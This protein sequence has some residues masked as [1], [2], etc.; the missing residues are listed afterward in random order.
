MNKVAKIIS[1]T[2]SPE[3]NSTLE[4]GESSDN[5]SHL[6]TQPQSLTALK[7]LRLFDIYKFSNM[8]THIG[9]VTCVGIFNRPTFV[10]Y[11]FVPIAYWLL[12]GLENC[13]RF[14]EWLRYFSR[15]LLSLIRFAAP[16]AALFVLFDTVYFYH[17]T[18][19]K[20]FNDVILK[21]RKLIF[22][23]YNFFAY[24]SKAENLREH[25][26]HPFHQH[27]LNCFLLFGFNH[28]ILMLICVQFF[29]QVLGSLSLGETN[30][31]M[32]AAIELYKQLINNTC[33]FFL[34]SFWV[35]LLV[36]SLVSHKEPRFLLPLLIP[37]CLLTSHCLFG[38]KS[39]AALRF[40]WIFFNLA[41]LFVFGFMHQGGVVPSLGYVQKMFSHVANLE[42][43]Q[44]VIFYHTYMPPRYLGKLTFLKK[45]IKNVLKK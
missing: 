17:I 19:A 14:S 30:S 10:I 11:A 15:R 28:L 12:Y 42:M 44:H 7:R 35:P 27:F 5:N 22:T 24:N 13:N 34:F 23:P 25:G 16:L 32:S 29:R 43:D 33:C 21:Q 18:S 20:Q 31:W 9:V 4:D 2:T 45:L 3:V 36:F 26:A 39:Y 38:A 1:A 8:S 6:L 41:S 37:V 40:V